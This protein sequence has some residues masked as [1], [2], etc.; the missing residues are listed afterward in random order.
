MLC[1]TDFDAA[2]D[3]ARQQ[4][5]TGSGLDPVLLE[6]R[7]AG[8]DKIDSIRIVKSAMNVSM[9]Q[10]KSLVDRSET[11]SDRYCDDQAFHGVVREAAEQLKRESGETEIIIEE[12]P[13]DP[14]PS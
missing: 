12:R 7:C 13:V 5:R 4:L 3:R 1:S 2:L 8:A 11:W 10:A 6:L 14:D 9:G